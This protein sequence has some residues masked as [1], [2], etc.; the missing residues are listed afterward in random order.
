[1]LERAG[2]FE[3]LEAESADGARA[4]LSD[5]SS[6][7]DVVLVELDLADSMASSLVQWVRQIPAL[8][9]IPIALTGGRPLD[10]GGPFIHRVGADAY[11]AKPFTLARLT[12]VVRSLAGRGGAVEDT[13]G[14]VYLRRAK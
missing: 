13:K 3:V 5:A 9:T 12:S 2:G 11:L 6:R 14:V 4:A 7:P 10:E 1:M 8:Q